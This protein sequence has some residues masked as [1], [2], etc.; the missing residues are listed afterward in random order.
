MMGTVKASAVVM[1]ATCEER[2]GTRMF[3]REQW[4]VFVSVILISRVI[5]RVLLKVSML[6]RKDK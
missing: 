6:K 1:H 3:D 2:D 5:N 4:T